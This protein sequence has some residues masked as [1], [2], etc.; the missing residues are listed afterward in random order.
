MTRNLDRRPRNERGRGHDRSN[1]FKR[2]RRRC[3]KWVCV[4]LQWQGDHDISNLDLQCLGKVL[5]IQAETEK[6]GWAIIER[7]FRARIAHTLP[8]VG[9]P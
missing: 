9:D 5:Q 8:G 6:T 2:K 1:G 7:P 3:T 4:S